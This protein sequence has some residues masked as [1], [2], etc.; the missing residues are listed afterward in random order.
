MEWPMEVSD[1]WRAWTELISAGPEDLA[2]IFRYVRLRGTVATQMTWARDW[3]TRTFCDLALHLL[4]LHHGPDLLT[5]R[6]EELRIFPNLQARTLADHASSFFVDPADADALNVDRFNGTWGNQAAFG[7]D[8]LAYLFRPGPYLRRLGALHPRLIAMADRL[9]LA[10]WVRYV[11]R[12]EIDSVLAHPLVPIHTLIET[13]L[14]RQA[15]VR[16]GVHRLR[17]LH[18][19]CWAGL[20]ERIFTSYGVTI[21]RDRHD[22]DWLAVAGRFATVAGGV[23]LFSQTRVSDADSEPAGEQLGQMVLELV[24]ALLS[25]SSADLVTRKLQQPVDAA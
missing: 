3:R 23:L 22:L 25:I 14:G 20:Y 19:R 2:E 15:A 12:A 13:V 24:P 16:E 17:V 5:G 1:E 8:L 10:E 6:P 9:T 4:Y 11:C 21:R 18:L 7:Q